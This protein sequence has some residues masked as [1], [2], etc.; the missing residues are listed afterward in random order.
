[1]RPR[2]KHLVLTILLFSF[3][4]LATQGDPGWEV[5]NGNG[6]YP[7]RSI[8]CVMV[9]TEYNIGV[10][11]IIRYGDYIYAGTWGTRGARVYR[12][13]IRYGGWENT[14][15]DL[16]GQGFTVTSFGIYD[17]GCESTPPGLY[18]GTWDNDGFDIYYL[19]D[20]AWMEVTKDGFGIPSMRAATTFIQYH[21]KLFVGTFRSSEEGG[22]KL[23]YIARDEGGAW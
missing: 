9:D 6:F 23:G 14:N 22:T 1:M 2:V 21:G 20:E 7:V 10:T 8:A 17:G 19:Q 16:Q 11:D 13:H 12:Q 5:V 3:P 18:V 15:I 4:L